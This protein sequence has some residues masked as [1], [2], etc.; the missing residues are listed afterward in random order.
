MLTLYDQSQKERESLCWLTQLSTNSRSELQTPASPINSIVEINHDKQSVIVLRAL[1]SWRTKAVPAPTR[2]E[3][4]AT[5]ACKTYHQME[6]Y[7]DR[8]VGTSRIPVS[9]VFQNF[10]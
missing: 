4:M 6:A 3:V 5:I 2:P 9:L 8:P 1:T 10:S 7:V